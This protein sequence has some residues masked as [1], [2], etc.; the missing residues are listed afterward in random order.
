MSHKLIAAAALVLA[1]AHTATAQSK[2]PVTAKPAA[3]VVKPVWPDE[4]PYFK[5]APRPTVTDITADDLRTRL[6]QL[7][8]DSMMGRKIGEL[9]NFKGTTYIASEFKRLGLKPAGDNGTYFQIL[10]W[11]FSGFDSTKARLTIAGAPV[12]IRTDWAPT[13]PTAANGVA[14]NVDLQNVATVFAGRAGDTT[15]HLDPAMFKGKIAVF[16]GTAAANG[17]ANFT[18]AGGNGRGGGGRGAGGRGPQSAC[19]DDQGWPESARRQVRARSCGGAGRGSRRAARG[20]PVAAGADRRLVMRRSRSGP[21]ACSWR[22]RWRS[23]CAP[24]GRRY[25]RER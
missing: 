19:S 15:T 4:S 20:A 21:W 9:G 22:C 11:G 14:A 5:W 12:A 24:L 8:D 7:A 25:C 17:G 3:S 10:D 18:A 2:A 6:Y 1:A 23:R 16:A 13:V